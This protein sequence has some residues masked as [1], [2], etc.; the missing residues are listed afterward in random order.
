[1][2]FTAFAS[3]DFAIR[4]YEYKKVT[5]FQLILAQYV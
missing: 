5:D 2:V 1:M 4:L 3:K